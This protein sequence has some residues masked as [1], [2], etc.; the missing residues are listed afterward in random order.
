MNGLSAQARPA[1]NALTTEQK[2]RHPH[3]HMLV[4]YQRKKSRED[5][6][7]LRGSTAVRLIAL[8]LHL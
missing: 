8:L 7:D 6:V 3:F 1:V 5:N 4:Q 2:G